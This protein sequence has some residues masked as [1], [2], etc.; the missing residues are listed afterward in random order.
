MRNPGL[1]MAA[2][3][4]GFLGANS[5]Q[6]NFDTCGAV[7][8]IKGTVEILRRQRA[9]AGDEVR[10]GF[11]VRRNTEPVECDD[12][13]LTGKESS[14]KVLLGE[15]R[16]TM[17]ADTRMELAKYTK[18]TPSAAPAV[19]LLSLSYGKLRSLVHRAKPK[20]D[21]PPTP[22]PGRKG[23]ELF[24]VKTYTAVVGVRGTDFYTA[25][26]P[27]TAVTEQAT[28]EGTVAVRRI[29]ADPKIDAETVE[30]TAGKQVTVEPA[31]DRLPEKLRQERKNDVAPALEVKRLL[32]VP[33]QESTKTDIR[34]VSAIAK[35]DSSFTSQQAV[36]VLGRPELWTDKKE[37]P[38]A[39]K[40]LK[41]EF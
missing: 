7:T 3:F 21:S 41:N 29:S 24:R 25:Y 1:F 37:D 18:K 36:E 12:I 38:P 8:G 11:I 4:T 27:N 40:D 2:L 5:A 16:L 23:A 32:V 30:V 22:V 14:A 10:Q 6:A 26:D 19:S 15:V 33:L 39:A 34:A 28:I 20:S 35:T 13:V 9:D 17:G 31:I